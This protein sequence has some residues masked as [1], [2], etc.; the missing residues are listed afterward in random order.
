MYISMSKLALIFFSLLPQKTHTHFQNHLKRKFQGSVVWNALLPTPETDI[1]YCFSL[2]L[3]FN[4]WLKSKGGQEVRMVQVNTSTASP[5]VVLC[6]TLDLLC[7]G[8]KLSEL[9]CLPSPQA[10]HASI[11]FKISTCACTS[12]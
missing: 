8:R 3:S 1:T 10:R 2:R 12:L 7:T 6:N 11:Y 9:C 5:R 4:H